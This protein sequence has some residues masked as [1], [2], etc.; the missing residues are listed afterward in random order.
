MPTTMTNS[1]IKQHVADGPIH[2][3][4][5]GSVLGDLLQNLS[6]ELVGE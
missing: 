5:A 6:N 2:P 4:A 1:L 3:T